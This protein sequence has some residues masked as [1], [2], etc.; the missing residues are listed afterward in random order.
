MSVSVLIVTFAAFITPM[1][2]QRFKISVL[3]TAVAE[4]LRWD[5]LAKVS[6]DLV[7]T[8]GIL[9][10]LSNYGV[11]FLL[12]LGVGWRSTFLFSRKITDHLPHWHAKAASA[13]RLH[14]FKSLLLRYGGSLLM[15]TSLSLA[16]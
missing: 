5:R 13:P 4:V 6:L 12:F 15:A 9:S 1:V 14:P 3:P 7:Q 8:E 11:I 2:L 10:F 16:L